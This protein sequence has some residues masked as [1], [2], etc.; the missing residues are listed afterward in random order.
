M[1]N[2]LLLCGC[3]GQGSQLHEDLWRVLL[4]ALP[5]LH[6]NLDTPLQCSLYNCAALDLQL[7]KLLILFL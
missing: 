1:A 6:L 7:C 2:V 3:K 5:L 4:P